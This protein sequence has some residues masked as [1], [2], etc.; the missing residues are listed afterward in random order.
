M[1]RF[2]VVKRIINDYLVEVEAETPA[3]AIEEA[4]ANNHDP[5]DCTSEWNDGDTFY[6]SSWIVMGE[7]DKAVESFDRSGLTDY[8]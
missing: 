8:D 4:M 5:G 3:K 1:A 7:D 2:K 6:P